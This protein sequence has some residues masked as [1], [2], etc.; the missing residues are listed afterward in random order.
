MKSRCKRK[1]GGERNE[2]NPPPPKIKNYNA[3][4]IWHSEDRASWYILIM[5]AKELH[6]FSNLFDEVLYIFRTSPLSIIRSISALYTWNRQISIARIQCRNTP[7]DGEWTCPKH[8]EYFIKWILE[9]VHLVGFHYMNVQ[10]FAIRNFSHSWFSQWPE[11][12]SKSA[13][14]VTGPPAERPRKCLSNPHRSKRF[15]SSMQAARNWD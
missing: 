6:Y 4:G 8:V 14:T 11:R 1:E 5:K 3:Q 12:R 2:R 9:I 10:G 15:F 7:D 13:S